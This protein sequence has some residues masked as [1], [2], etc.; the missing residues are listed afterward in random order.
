MRIDAYN[1]VSQLY[2]AQATTKTSKAYG[3]KAFSS[4]DQVEIS[5]VGRDYQVAKQAV[6]GAADVREDLVAQMKER[7]AKGTYEVSVDDFANKL[8][9][10]FSAIV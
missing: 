6:A 8:M 3:N 4:Y 10:K 2:K 5:Q 1:Q 9:E 7:L